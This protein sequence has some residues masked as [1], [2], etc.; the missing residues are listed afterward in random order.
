MQRKASFKIFVTRRE[1][2]YVGDVPDHSLMLT[3]MEGEPIDYIP[4]VAGAFVSRRSVGFH[5]RI[6]GDGPM[7]GYAC[8]IYENGAVYSKFRGE[9]MGS[10]TK[11]KWEAYKG[12]GKLSTV[13]GTGTFV[14]KP[15]EKHGEFVLEMEG[16]YE[17]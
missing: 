12:I 9:K 1:S 3:E 17:L 6:K 2:L 5:D 8:T 13:K 16:T 10:K 11:G 7:T 15:T 14:V 4:G